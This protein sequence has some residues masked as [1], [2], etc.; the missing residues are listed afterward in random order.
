VASAKVAHR[1]IEAHERRDWT[2][3]EATL[4]ALREAG[5]ELDDRVEGIGVD[6]VANGAVERIAA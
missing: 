4:R 1:L 6:A 5:D 3:D 2:P